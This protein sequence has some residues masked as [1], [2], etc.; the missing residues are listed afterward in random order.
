MS[1]AMPPGP[2]DP[3]SRQSV[4]LRTMLLAVFLLG[5]LGTAIE[6]VLL[7]HYSEL[8]QLVPLGAIL[9][10]LVV[11]AMWFLS[12]ARAVL[13]VF[14]VSMLVFVVA[15]LVGIWLHYESNLEFELEMDPSAEGWSLIWASLSG[16]M[17]ALAPG[18]MVQLGLV[19]LLYT[20]GH[21]GLAA[22]GGQASEA[23]GE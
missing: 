16:A 9:A 6:L 8:A 13:R 21:P 7:E 18:T 12:Q 5:A 2:G 17:P 4:V 15:G 3:R 19:G 10:G 14:Q 23:S 11:L 20:Y 22:P 1:Q